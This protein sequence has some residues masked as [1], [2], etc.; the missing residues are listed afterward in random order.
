MYSIKILTADHF[1]NDFT[2]ICKNLQIL[3]T[4]KAQSWFWRYHKRVETIEWDHFCAEIRYQ[5]KDFKTDSDILEELRNRKQKS[6]ENFETFFESVSTIMDRLNR[7]IEEMELIEI[8]KKNL[9]P[10]IRHEL[11]YVPICSVAHLRK[12]VQMREDLLSEDNFRRNNPA[13]PNF[14]FPRKN[15]AAVESCDEFPTEPIASHEATVDALNQASTI[16]KCWN[17]NEPGH[18]WEDCLRDRVV[19]CYGCGT[20]NVYK[21]Q[22]PKYASKRLLGGKLYNPANQPKN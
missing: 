18:L 20:K 15:I 14:N 1:D 22:C 12:L 6:S 8:L 13:K 17:C 16:M 9:R 21:P 4:G 7:Q 5:Y 3:L 2:V 10:D 19:F 11:L